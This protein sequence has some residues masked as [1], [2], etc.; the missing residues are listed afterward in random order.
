MY[1]VF[2]TKTDLTFN[3]Q[4]SISMPIANRI[5][6]TTPTYFHVDNPINPHM[7]Q[8]NGNLHKM[9]KNKA[10]EQWENLKN[11]YKKIGYSPDI[12]NGVPNLPDMVFCANQAFPFLTKT[13]QKKA[14]LSN[15]ANDTRNKEVEHVSKFLNSR[16]VETTPLPTRNNNTLFEAMGDCLWLPGKRFMLGGYGHRTSHKIYEHVANVC[17]SNVAIFELTNP[18]FYHLDTC[19]AVLNST[20]AIA[21]KQA[22]S[23]SGWEL[24]SHIFPSLIEVSSNEADSP[25]FACNAH[26]PDE[27]HVILQKGSKQ[28]NGKLKTAGFE[29]IEVDTSEFIKSGG[30]VFCM[31]LM[32]F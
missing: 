29:T 18:R 24:L 27:K 11:T 20:T 5:F 22:F 3:P 2:R 16:S 9:D 13:G 26:C 1:H 8:L 17:E 12:L 19:L 25:Q 30:S 14:L 32:Y 4:N 31:K 6:M 21:H 23:A 7:R 15:M 28:L 10:I